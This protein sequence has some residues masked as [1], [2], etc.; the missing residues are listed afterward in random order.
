MPVRMP[1]L[2]ARI[3]AGW[4]VAWTR[5]DRVSPEPASMARRA[6]IP[7]PASAIAGAPFLRDRQ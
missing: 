1:A 3:I 4:I 6:E 7:I 5:P 2:P